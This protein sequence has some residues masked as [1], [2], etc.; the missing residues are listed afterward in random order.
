MNSYYL[1]D[2]NLSEGSKV[3]CKANLSAPWFEV[4]QVY[5]VVRRNVVRDAR[6]NTF[7]NPSARFVPSEPQQES[8]V[9]RL[10]DFIIGII[11]VVFATGMLYEVW[12]PVGEISWLS[13][14]LQ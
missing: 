4:G 9:M 10:E 14:L 8:F 7:E 11:S 5:T 1:D 12:K 3:V 2:M 13:S 6:G